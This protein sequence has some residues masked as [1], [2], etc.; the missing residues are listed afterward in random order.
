MMERTFPTN[1]WDVNLLSIPETEFLELSERVKEL[2]ETDISVELNL[3]E[4]E[5]RVLIR[6]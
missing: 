5:N 3:D 2:T 6:V 1:C 4:A